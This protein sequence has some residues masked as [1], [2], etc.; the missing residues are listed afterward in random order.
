MFALRA[1]SS[2]VPAVSASYRQCS[3]DIQKIHRISV[4]E[5]SKKNKNLFH[6]LFIFWK[7]NQRLLEIT[8][9][10]NKS[11]KQIYLSISYYVS[12][13]CFYNILST[14]E[15]IL[16]FSIIHNITTMTNDCDYETTL[17]V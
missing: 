13:K 3:L 9:K 14:T 7:T 2:K 10:S 4:G 8:I 11:R 15:L 1:L 6:D 16:N 12:S 5:R 17:G